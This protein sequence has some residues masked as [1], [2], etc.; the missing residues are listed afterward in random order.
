MK[1]DEIMEK[2]LDEKLNKTG[3]D[4]QDTEQKSL[5]KRISILEKELMKM[6]E[7]LRRVKTTIK[8]K[9]GVDLF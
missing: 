2:E 9:L 6:K 8:E 1:I 4:I 7:D 5:N 3:E